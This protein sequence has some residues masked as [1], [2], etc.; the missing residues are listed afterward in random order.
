MCPFSR[1]L[2]LHAAFFPCIT[3]FVFAAL[4]ESSPADIS[5]PGAGGGLTPAAEPSPKEQPGKSLIEILASLGVNA[6]EKNAARLKGS[7]PEFKPAV[8][9]PDEDTIYGWIKGLCSTAHRRPGT[10]EGHRARDWVAER[11][12][13]AGLDDVRQERV[14]MTVW[15][16]EECS[17]SVEGISFDCF[18]INNSGFTP[19]GG[20]TAPLVHI[21]EGGLAGFFG[22]NVKHKI[23]VAEASMKPASDPVAFSFAPV[24]E[25]PPGIAARQLAVPR[26]L[27]KLP[28][29]DV[30][31][32]AKAAGA[33]G[34][35]VILADS[36][37]KDKALYW[38]HDAS[39]R[40]IPGLYVGER[41]GRVLRELAKEGKIANL[42]LKGKAEQGWSSFVWGALPGASKEVILVA[43]HHDS[44]Y[45]GAV[46][47]AG[48]AQVLAQAWAWSRVPEAQRP[49]TL[50]FVSSGCHLYDDA[51]ARAFAKAH[52]EILG[53]ASALL[54]IDHVPAR[55]PSA[56]ANGEA[57]G[58]GR[59]E[60]STIYT[61]P[62]PSIVAAVWKAVER[63]PADA[64]TCAP[65]FPDLPISEAAG[66]LEWSRDKSSGYSRRGG[67]PYVSWVGAPADLLGTR[68]TLEK[69]DRRRLRPTAET[70]A[71]MIKSFMVMP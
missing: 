7:I 46:S 55:E 9:V 48:L 38:P 1:R 66:Y 45:R 44:P 60:V 50:V 52:P 5:L 16:P 47:A 18:Y 56:G 41:E 42:I 59:P 32:Q 23:V 49:R 70:I 54:A 12:R 27:G 11:F 58:K 61:C 20:V 6:L 34:T 4:P 37:S 65:G 24:R 30:A 53:R 33:V 25:T 13:A 35:I 21:G 62:D 51:G 2:G 19:S 28:L 69:V 31:T 64:T 71:E 26:N 22:K 17:L 67:L 8:K 14:P 39:F 3:A 68:D 10:E 43:G 29:L 40:A 36:P 63:A 15:T 57:G